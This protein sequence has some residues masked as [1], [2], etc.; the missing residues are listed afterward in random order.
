MTLWVSVS[1]RCGYL[2]PI[3]PASFTIFIKAWTQGSLVKSRGRLFV[4]QGSIEIQY[5]HNCTTLWTSKCLFFRHNFDFA[6]YPGFVLFHLRKRAA[7]DRCTCRPSCM[8]IILE[9]VAM[10]MICWVTRCLD[11][12]CFH[13]NITRIISQVFLLGTCTFVSLII[14]TIL[15]CSPS[16]ALLH[17]RWSFL[18][19]GHMII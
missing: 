15:E 4:G 13:W 18:F 6:V 7:E 17:G 8:V 10:I 14:T 3:K 12:S 5:T 19:G 2:R 16:I 1:V 9:Y 11:I